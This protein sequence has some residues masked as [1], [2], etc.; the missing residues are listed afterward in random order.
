VK[1]LEDSGPSFFIL[2]FLSFFF[3]LFQAELDQSRN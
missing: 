1:R 3:N 2:L